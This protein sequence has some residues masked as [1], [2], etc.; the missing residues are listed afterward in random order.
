MHV[1]L[2]FDTCGAFD[3]LKDAPILNCYLGLTRNVVSQL[4]FTSF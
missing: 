4:L 3:L 1:F 2:K